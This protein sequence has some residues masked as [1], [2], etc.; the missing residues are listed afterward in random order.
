MV[1]KSWCKCADAE[2]RVDDKEKCR[3]KLTVLVKKGYQQ[4]VVLQAYHVGK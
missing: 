3:T 4:F 1:V 2:K